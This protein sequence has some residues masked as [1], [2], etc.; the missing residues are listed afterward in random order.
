MGVPSIVPLGRNCKPSGRGGSDSHDSTVGPALEGV[1]ETWVLT[2]RGISKEGHC[3]P[4]GDGIFT[5][6]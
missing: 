3:M 6:M 5:S 4:D 2:R 1:M